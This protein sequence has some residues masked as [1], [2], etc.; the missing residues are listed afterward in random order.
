MVAHPPT[1]SAS[2]SS[3]APTYF[4]DDAGRG[5][6]LQG[7]NVIEFVVEN[8][9]VDVNPT[10]LR[11]DAIVRTGDDGPPAPIVFVRGDAD[12]NGAINL[13]DGIRIL[14]FL[15]LGE[16]APECMDAAD[17]A[18]SGGERPALTDAVGGPDRGPPGLRPGGGGVPAVERGCFFRDRGIPGTEAA[19]GS[20]WKRT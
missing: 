1:W 6:F 15:F 4:P 2:L 10:G 12:S 3:V 5:L 8:A 18:D 7:E 14:A 16:A 17:A 11:V 13:T 20:L 19:P 9:G